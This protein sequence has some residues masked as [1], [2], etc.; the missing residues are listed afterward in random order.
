MIEKS[1]CECCE[2]QIFHIQFEPTDVTYN[3]ENFYV[4]LTEDEA[5]Q[6]HLCLRE[7]VLGLGA[8]V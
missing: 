8:A 6:L 1:Q 2:E 7:E 3:G 5:M 4:H